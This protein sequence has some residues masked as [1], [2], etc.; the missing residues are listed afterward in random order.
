MSNSFFSFLLND[1]GKQVLDIVNKHSYKKVIN[2]PDITIEDGTGFWAR[3][4]NGLQSDTNIEHGEDYGFLTD[5]TNKITM[6]IP[7][8]YDNNSYQWDVHILHELND[9]YSQMFPFIELIKNG[10]Q[11]ISIVMEK[12]Y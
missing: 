1:F 11:S 3:F 2:E 4:N 6:Y 10:D 5:R 12:E 8:D 9:K 7:L